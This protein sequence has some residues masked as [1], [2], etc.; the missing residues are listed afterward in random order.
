MKK[1]LSI[2]IIAALILSCLVVSLAGCSGGVVKYG[3]SETGVSPSPSSDASGKI[4]VGDV[5][6]KVYY[7][8]DMSIYSADQA[9]TSALIKSKAAECGGYVQTGRESSGEYWQDRYYTVRIPTDRLDEYV[10]AISEGN[11]VA[12]KYVSTIDITTEYVSVQARIDA[13]TAERDALNTLLGSASTTADVIA[14]SDR[15]SDINA[16]LG[17]L[18]RELNEYDSLVDYSTVNISVYKE[19][20][21]EK[22]DRSFGERIADIFVKSFKSIGTVAKWIFVALIAVIPYFLLLSVVGGV[23]F[24]IVILVRKKKGLPLFRK[25]N[26]QQDKADKDETKVEDDNNEEKKDE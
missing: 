6:R 23:V 24:G 18:Q 9:A 20:V 21:E 22:D 11:R 15:I 1:K 16:E 5:S 4:V 8:V 10:A 25:K 12:E 19:N 14:I 7:T 17:A 3:D 13:L 26:A 2:I